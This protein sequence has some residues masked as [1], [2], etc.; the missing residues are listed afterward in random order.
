MR[1]AVLVLTLAALVGCASLEKDF[2]TFE[3]VKTDEEAMH[4]RFKA[5]AGTN[6]PRDDPESERV[7]IDALVMWLADNGHAGKEY[8]ILSRTDVVKSDSVFGKVYELYYEVRV[9]R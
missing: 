3:P 6:S 1:F 5:M 7:R 4:Y 8:Q 2:T 9:P